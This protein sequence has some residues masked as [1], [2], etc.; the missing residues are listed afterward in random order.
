VIT[1][2]LLH[3]S[4]PESLRCWTFEDKTLIRI[5]RA[6][7]NDIILFSAVVS[8]Y[9]IQVQKQEDVW[10]LENLGANGTF[11]NGKPIRKT[12]VSDRMVFSL[13]GSGPKIQIFLGAYPE[14]SGIAVDT[15]LSDTAEAENLK[16][17]VI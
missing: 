13:A 12:V 3:P 9:H 4:K 11:F 8:R 2:A 1:L 14:Q 5:G 7:D 17:T 6:T 10:E 15:T 16:Q